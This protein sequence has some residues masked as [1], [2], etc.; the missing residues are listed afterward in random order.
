MNLDMEPILI[1]GA[2]RS[3]TSLCAGSI[4]ICGAWGGQLSGPTKYNRKGMFENSEIRNAIVKPYLRDIGCDPLGQKP[5]PDIN[6][7]RDVNSLMVARW[8]K[9]IV[10]LVRKQGYKDGP[11]F[12]KGAKMCLMW[13]LWNAAF[14]DAH[15][16]VV[17]RDSED[18]VTSCLKT[19]FMRAYR[20]RSGWLQWV[21][22]HEMRFEEMYDAKLKVQE[23]WP[24]RAINGD[25][26]Q[27]QMV[28]NN[29]G[30]D[31]KFDEVKGFIEPTL[32]HK[33]KRER[34]HHG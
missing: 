31:W 7:V 5:L 19:S 2:A 17:R 21:A 14:P 22:E 18:I 34:T 15:W 3:G 16:V 13:P 24:Q 30:L 20:S 23:V 27:L 9:Q 28:V 25:L 10:D 26:T 11:W 29:L 33:S 6:K 4:N 32:W 1:T 12:Y 8:R